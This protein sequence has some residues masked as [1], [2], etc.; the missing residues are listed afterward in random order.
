MT[1]KGEE[2][3]GMSQSGDSQS[4]LFLDKIYDHSKQL[5]TLN[6]GVAGLF[7]TFYNKQLTS[8]LFACLVALAV[9]GIF[10]MAA[11]TLVTRMIGQGYTYYTQN[12]SN[13]TGRG[14]ALFWLH[15]GSV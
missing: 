5:V 12:S 8:G 3:M 2:P 6:T 4:L 14:R 15:L 9:G 11:L 7:V 10:A 1:P 13:V